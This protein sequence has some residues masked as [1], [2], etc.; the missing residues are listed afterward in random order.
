MRQR[1]IE[2]HRPVEILL[3][4]FRSGTGPKSQNVDETR[5]KPNMR[6]F[7]ITITL[8]IQTRTEWRFA[9]PPR[10]VNLVT[11]KNFLASYLN[12]FI[13]LLKFSQKDH[14]LKK[15]TKDFERQNQLINLS[16]SLN[17]LK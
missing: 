11:T 16:E 3:D 8:T 12:F 10:G 5:S 14:F 17:R 13:A 4:R 7:S 9:P 2:Y 6:I 15:H 1:H